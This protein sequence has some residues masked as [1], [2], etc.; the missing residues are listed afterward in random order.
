VRADRLL[1]ARGLARSRA[2]AL[3]LLEAGAVQWRAAAAAAWQPVAKP[4]QEL[5]AA[6]E[7]RLDGAPGELRYVSRGGVKLE[8]ALAAGGVDPAGKT[9]LDL[10]QSTG[11]FTDCLLQRGAARVVGI[12][13]GHGQLH[14]RLAADARVLAFERVNARALERAA[15]DAL[16]AARGAA[17]LPEAGFELIVG[18][19]SFISLT[20]VLPALAP[21]LVPGGDLLHLVKPQFELGAAALDGR[22][23]VRPDADLRPMFERI[24]AAL[25][26]ESWDRHSYFESSIEGGDGNREYFLHARRRLGPDGA[27]RAP[28]AAF[29]IDPSS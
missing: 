16:V 14:P 23:I 6:A 12:D 7:L 24:S 5:P 11:G 22:G 1:V 13:V 26:R 29:I 19:L 18:D 8:G 28:G 2:Q 15:L 4:A 17:A 10:G 25:P 27:G 20:L 21:L 3:R 9:C